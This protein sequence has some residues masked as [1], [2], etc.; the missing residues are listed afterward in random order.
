MSASFDADAELGAFR[1]AQR[2]R[3]RALRRGAG[4]AL[5]DAVVANVNRVVD[6][7]LLERPHACMAFYW[8]IHDEIALLSAML[9]AAERGAAVALPVVVAHDAPLVFRSWRKDIAMEPGTWNIPVPTATAVELDPCALFVPL[10]GYDDAGYR[11]GNGGGFYDRTLAVRVPRPLAIGVGFEAL[12]MHSI[13]PH[14]HDMP[15][16]LVV[17]EASLDEALIATRLRSRR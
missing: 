7:M 3:C 11:L 8:P 1:R 10:V 14:D 15:M 16:D 17:T 2:E 4:Q 12:R 13:R 9:R 5:R 6:A